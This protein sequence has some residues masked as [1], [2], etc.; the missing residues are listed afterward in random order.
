MSFI[1][2]NFRF[3]QKY[4][5]FRIQYI[6]R[7]RS[8]YNHE[9]K[10]IFFFICQKCSVLKGLRRKVGTWSGN[11]AHSRVDSHVRVVDSLS[12]VVD[13]LAFCSKILHQDY[14]LS[15]RDYQLPYWDYQ[16]PHWD[17]QLLSCDYLPSS[18]QCFH[19]V[20]YFTGSRNQWSNN[21]ITTILHSTVT[22]YF[23]TWI[24]LIM[25]NIKISQQ[26]ARLLYSII[27]KINILTILNYISTIIHVLK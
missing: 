12:V 22:K 5:N 23:K 13:S 15:H 14:Q 9:R 21:I 25:E 2:K 4:A 7:A 27:N 1:S 6:Y 26:A 20:Y 3:R 19:F 18:A 17:Y 8:V 10:C 11:I 24:W 16:L